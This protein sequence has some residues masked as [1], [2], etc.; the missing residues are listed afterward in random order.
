M[1]PAGLEENVRALAGQVDA[2]QLLFFESK[3][4]SLLDHPVDVDFLGE[5]AGDHNLS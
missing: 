5:V 2:V 4:N 1:L 3:A